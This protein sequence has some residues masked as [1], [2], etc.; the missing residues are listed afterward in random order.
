MDDCNDRGGTDGQVS[1]R[2]KLVVGFKVRALEFG[3]T[4]GQS[5][6]SQ[7]RLW[8]GGGSPKPWPPVSVSGV[9]LG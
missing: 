1:E 3:R 4:Q 8:P 6:F 2:K 5:F 7:E 9:R